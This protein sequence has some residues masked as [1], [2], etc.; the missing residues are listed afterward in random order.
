[1]DWYAQNTWKNWTI[2]D[3]YFGGVYRTKVASWSVT[4]STNYGIDVRPQDAGGILSSTTFSGGM[5]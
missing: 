5:A 2:N 1:M 4:S 3:N